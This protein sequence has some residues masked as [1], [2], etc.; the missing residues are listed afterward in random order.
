MGMYWSCP[1]KMMN[2]QFIKR[3][4]DDLKDNVLLNIITFVTIALSVLIIGTFALFMVNAGNIIHSWEKGVRIIVYI[5]NNVQPVEIDNLKNDIRQMEGVA[6]IKFISKQDGLERLKKQMQG[7][8]SLLENLADN[9]LPDTLE[10]WVAPKH[11]TW[12]QIEMLAIHIESSHLV[13]D[14][15][16][17]Q[18]WMKRFTGF[19]NLFKVTGGLM[20]AVFFM[21]VIFII[22]NTIRL[23]FF[24]KSDEIK[25][26]RLVGATDNFIRAPFYIEG[27]ILGGA[28]GIAGI[29]ALYLAYVL[30]ITNID[31]NF[32]S[33]YFTIKFLPFTITLAIILFSMLTGW[34][35]CYISLKQLLRN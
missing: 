27:L 14:V 9:P 18:N 33:F 5:K 34:I 24:P 26:M 11:K 32:V 21:A 35:G 19:L 30:V 8:L 17:G 13:E 31:L 16:Y 23:L 1:I 4:V 6:D 20:G 10:V 2:R 29:L 12:K 25:I 3:A 22:A 28:G 7:Q 15:E